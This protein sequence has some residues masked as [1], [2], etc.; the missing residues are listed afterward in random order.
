MDHTG[1]GNE[2]DWMQGVENLFKDAE[3]GGRLGELAAAAAAGEGQGQAL[4]VSEEAARPK[5]AGAVSGM[6]AAIAVTINAEMEKLLR[7]ELAVTKAAVLELA[8]ES[9]RLK[10]ELE[11]EAT[12]ADQA[13]EGEA[14]ATSSAV[15]PTG[16]LSTDVGELQ[17]KAQEMQEQI[18]RWQ[19]EMQSLREDVV[20]ARDEKVEEETKVLGWVRELQEGGDGEGK[21]RDKLRALIK[22]IGALVGLSG[23]DVG[24]PLPFVS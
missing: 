14:M 17:A 6:A 4:S 9:L 1:E 13:T 8:R 10:G 7:D 24:L 18:S 11:Q 3:A 19:D 20:V 12:L 23:L 21:E 5:A 15:L 2:G 16:I 22:Q